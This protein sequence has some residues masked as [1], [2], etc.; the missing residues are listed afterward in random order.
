MLLG[1]ERALEKKNDQ[2]K[3]NTKVIPLS[4]TG[5]KEKETIKA[6]KGVAEKNQQPGLPEQ[7]A[8]KQ[9]T[10]T[11]LLARVG[12][13][14]EKLR[15]R[16]Y[17][18]VKNFLDSV[19]RVRVSSPKQE[20]ARNRQDNGRVANLAANKV[21]AQVS[22]KTAVPDQKND[23]KKEVKQDVD[24]A[25]NQ[26]KSGP[27]LAKVAKADQS[28]ASLKQR[29]IKNEQPSG[30]PQK[31]VKMDSRDR[32]KTVVASTPKFKQD[33]GNDFYQRQG[34]AHGVSQKEIDALRQRASQ[35]KEQAKKVN[36][37]QEK[38]PERKVKGETDYKKVYEQKVGGD[39]KKKRSVGESGLRVDTHR[40][41][42]DNFRE[43]ATRNYKELSRAAQIRMDQKAQIAPKQ[44]KKQTQKL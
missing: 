21:A 10:R 43:N 44:E 25:V 1:S 42:V 12:Q 17:S 11:G 19:P 7:E 9:Q 20:A 3:D 14:V 41:M 29:T 24:R 28:T 13:A 6:T 22:N 2:R 32:A 18:A 38:S 30:L 5:N 27:V 37:Q 35:Q 8:K 31:G 36:Q 26:I 40:D 33:S 34:S 4:Q 39:N 15:E 23:N 16:T